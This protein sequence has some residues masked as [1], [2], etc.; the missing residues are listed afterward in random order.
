MSSL[1]MKRGRRSLSV[2]WAA[3]MGAGMTSRDEVHCET[4][5]RTGSGIWF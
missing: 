4:A 1:S 3:L 2:D 5:I